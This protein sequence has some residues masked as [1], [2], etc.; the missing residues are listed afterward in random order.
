VNKKKFKDRPLIMAP[1][2]TIFLCCLIAGAGVH[3]LFR[4]TLGS[5]P[6]AARPWTGGGLLA[7]AGLIAASAFL[8]L[9]RHK[10]PFNP[11]KATIRIVQTGVFR[12]S[13]NPMYLSL[14]LLLFAAAF[15]FNAFSFIL[16]AMVFMVIV[17]H[18]VI[19]PEETYLERKFGDEYRAYTAKVRR[20]ALAVKRS[21]VKRV[22]SNFPGYHPIWYSSENRSS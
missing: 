16:M 10:T 9:R 7:L 15:L 11:Y 20:W 19:Q 12:F 3:A 5:F 1:P 17:N 22:D 18:G 21:V 13:R 4:A 8:A 14:A 2:P 6:E